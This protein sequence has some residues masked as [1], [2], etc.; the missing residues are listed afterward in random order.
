MKKLAPLVFIALIAVLAFSC[1]KEESVNNRPGSKHKLKS[2][3]ISVIEPGGVPYTESFDLFY[4]DQDRIVQAKATNLPNSGFEYTYF[5]D[6]YIME[7]TGNG[8]VLVHGTFYLNNNMMVDS[9]FQYNNE[10]D[11]TVTKYVYNNNKQ[12]IQQRFYDYS[13]FFGASLTSTLNY[14]YDANGLLTTETDGNLEITYVYDKVIHNTVTTGA[15]YMPM[16]KQLPTQAIYKMGLD[17][18]TIDY[19]Y[20]FDSQN[21]L[22]SE[23]AVASGGGMSTT[24]YTYF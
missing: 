15:P 5:P 14:Q 17:T 22:I 10:Q 19:T 21:R 7:I 6:H 20:N 18:E 23:V 13:T 11:T 9:L 8:Q 16:P 2:Y 24:T 4:D 12:L 3:S 1:T